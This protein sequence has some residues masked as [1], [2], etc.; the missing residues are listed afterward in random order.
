[1]HEKNSYHIGNSANYFI[2]GNL[3]PDWN[4]FIDTLVLKIER[5]FGDQINPDQEFMIL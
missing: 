1:M 5:A 4:V 3:R 2:P